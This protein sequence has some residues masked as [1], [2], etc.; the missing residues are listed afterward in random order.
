MGTGSDVDRVN[1]SQWQLLK[2][3]VGKDLVVT[4]TDVDISSS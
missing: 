2:T 3:V 4:V 1:F